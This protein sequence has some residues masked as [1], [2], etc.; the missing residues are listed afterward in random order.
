LPD[1]SVSG[2]RRLNAATSVAAEVRPKSGWSV[3]S[4]GIG[5]DAGHSSAGNELKTQLKTEGRVQDRD[6]RHIHSLPGSLAAT[7]QP[8][9]LPASNV[10]ISFTDRLLSSSIYHGQ[11]IA[12]RRR[13]QTLTF[14]VL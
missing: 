1:H 9:S 4:A 12:Q 5:R 13:Q 2:S 11:G 7:H 3:E 10:L 8:L 6:A 14:Q